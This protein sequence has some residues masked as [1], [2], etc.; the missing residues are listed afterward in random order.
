MEHE[1]PWATTRALGGRTDGSWDAYHALR[2]EC[3]ALAKEQQFSDRRMGRTDPREGHQGDGIVAGPD[4]GAV[5]AP[6]P[7]TD[8]PAIRTLVARIDVDADR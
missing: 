7:D 3:N 8:V 5:H 1:T 6:D 4:R 2:E